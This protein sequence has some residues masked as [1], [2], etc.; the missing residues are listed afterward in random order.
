[1]A[2]ET[3]VRSVKVSRRAGRR[4][5]RASVQ[6]TILR[7]CPGVYF[8]NETPLAS[9]AGTSTFRVDGPIPCRDF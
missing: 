8:L 6:Q 4:C 1:M 5:D 3:W 9:I 2:C 7:E